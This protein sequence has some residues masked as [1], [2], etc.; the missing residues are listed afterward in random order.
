MFSLREKIESL[1]KQLLP[2][3]RAFQSPYNGWLT[4]LNRALAI[5]EN[6]AYNDALDI[7]DAILPD[8]EGFTEEDATDWERRLG[9]IVSPGVTFE[10]RKLAIKRKLAHPGRVKARQNYLY[11][12]SQLQAAG[13]DLYVYENFTSIPIRPFTTIIANYVDEDLDAATFTVPVIFRGTFFIGSNPYGFANVPI[14]R[15]DEYRQ[16]VLRLKPAQMVA[17][18][19]T[20]YV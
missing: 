2:T 12:E 4:T 16:L 8:N 10:D 20:N 19:L 5:S 17:Y 14:E 13:F 9:M 6:K 7:L 3:G 1:F 15:K 11:I 18:S